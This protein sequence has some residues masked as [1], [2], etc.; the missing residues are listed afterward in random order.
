MSEL[1]K[2]GRHIR[3]ILEWRQTLE[4]KGKDVVEKAK[5]WQKEE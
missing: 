2:L 1:R 3:F 4:R 5:S